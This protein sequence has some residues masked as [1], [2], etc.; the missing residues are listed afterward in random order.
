MAPRD[1]SKPDTTADT[2]KADSTPAAST[3]TPAEPQ[4]VVIEQAPAE[5]AVFYGE[6]GLVPGSG[7][8]T[9]P[10]KPHV[11]AHYQPFDW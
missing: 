10:N 1:T 9:D 2:D 5:P 4:R 3:S 6:G 8:A 11:K 7:N